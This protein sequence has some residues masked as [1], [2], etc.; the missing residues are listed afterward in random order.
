MKAK[1]EN[2]MVTFAGVKTYMKDGVEKRFPQMRVL[3][4]ENG[5]T[6]EFRCTEEMVS[7]AKAMQMHNIEISIVKK[8]FDGKESLSHEIAEIELV[9]DV[10]ALKAVNQ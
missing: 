6:I 1:L 5:D 2:V 7:K 3:D 10:K 4:A 9:S 8:K